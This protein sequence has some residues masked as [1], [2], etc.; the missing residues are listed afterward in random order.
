MVCRDGKSQR[1]VERETGINRKTIRKYVKEYE[2]KR[3]ELLN[4][5]ATGDVRELTDSIVEAPKYNSSTR[6]K[7][8]LTDE[9]IKEIQG[10]L[11]ENKEKIARGQR[12]Q[13]KKKIDIFE[14]L[15]EQGFEI[16]YSTVCNTVRS[17][18]NKGAEAY[19]RAHYAL[20]DVCEFDWGEVKIFIDGQLR[21]LQMAVFTSAK[22]NYRYAILFAKQDTSCFLESH[23][24]FFEHIGGVYQT[25]VYDNMKV[26]VRKFVGTEKE[27]TEALLKLS[28]YYGFQFRFCNVRKG[29][30]KG[31]VEKSVEYIRRKAFSAKDSFASIE[32]ANSY[33]ANICQRLNLKPQSSNGNQVAAEVLEEETP[34]LLPKLPMYDAAKITE[35]RVSKYSTITVN[36][37]HYSVPDQFVG[38]M[39]LTKIYTNQII[40]Y[41]QG[42]VVAKHSRKLGH[43]EWS[44]QLEHYL[45]TLKKKPGAIASSVALHQAN[46]KLQQIYASYYI[47]K[48]RDFVDLIYFISEK[49]LEVVEKAIDTL[50]RINTLEVTT[51]KIK[52]ICSRKQ[53]IKPNYIQTNNNDILA[54][55]LA[56]LKSFEQLVPAASDEFKKEVAII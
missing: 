53:E 6:A 56:M 50:I 27:P 7:R 28:L 32:E 48:E 37:C 45:G 49:G 10:Y 42:Q 13:Q 29:N 8:K 36:S 26:A 12:K 31:H 52:A 40:C 24:L 55:S 20:G 44:I 22:G 3:Q 23:A 47:T 46:P 25:L 30:E 1:A 9:V 39:I 34:Y 33:L 4:N 38:K 15:C 11:E 17:L 5:G 21:V 2:S 51:E 16:S 43:C 19:I 41:W 14:A 54:H 35:L 18:E